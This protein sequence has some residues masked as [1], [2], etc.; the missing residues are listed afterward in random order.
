MVVHISSGTSALVCALVL[1]SRVGYPHEP[2]PPHRVVLSL[3][4][5]GLA[6]GRL[7]RIQRR[8]RPGFGRI[9]HAGFRGNPFLSGRGR[10]ELGRDRMVPQRQ[11]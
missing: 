7:V 5:T 1:G 6:L 2:M 8:E 11:A 10:A 3:I 9:G 4:G